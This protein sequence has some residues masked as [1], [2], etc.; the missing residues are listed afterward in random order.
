MSEQSVIFVDLSANHLYLDACSQEN[1]FRPLGVKMSFY[2]NPEFR[3]NLLQMTY[4]D[5]E[6]KILPWSNRTE[7]IE[8][9][10]EKGEH[11]VP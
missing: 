3:K 8:Q 9:D 10:P 7:L 5:P 2:L 6:G 11:R 1:I 4:S